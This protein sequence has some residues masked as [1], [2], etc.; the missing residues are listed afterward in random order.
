MPRTIA[1]ITQLAKT[2]PG[3]LTPAEVRFLRQEK[4]RQQ[5]RMFDDVPAPVEE[6]ERDA[7]VEAKRARRESAR[8]IAR[9]MT[10]IADPIRRRDLEADPAA[11]LKHYLPGIFYKPFSAN[12]QK[13][14][15]GTWSILK[16]GG[17]KIILDHRGGGKSST[18]RGVQ[19]LGALSGQVRFSPIIGKNF[20]EGLRNLNIQKRILETSEELLA[21]Y[22]EACVP[23]RR[24]E[25]VSQRASTM[26]YRGEVLQFEWKPDFVQ[27]PIIDGRGGGVL[28]ATGIDG[29][30]IRGISVFT[31]GDI[32][33]PDLVLLD[34]LQDEESARS[35]LQTEKIMDT[36]KQSVL[37]G[38]G[39]GEQFGVM[40][41]MTCIAP[42]DVADRLAN[43]DLYPTWRGERLKMVYA[44]P[45][46]M[47][48]W[49]A[50]E[51]IVL[52]AMNGEGEYRGIHCIEA[53]NDFVRD[54][55]EAMHEGA[56]LGSAYL[57]IDRSGETD[58]VS[59]LQYAMNERI[60][61]GREA[62]E[63]E[64]NNNPISLTSQPILT[65]TPYLVQSKLLGHPRGVVPDG[66][67]RLWCGCDVGKNYLHAVVGVTPARNRIVHVIDYFRVEI[68]A[69]DGDARDR[70]SAAHQLLDA[71]IYEALAHLRNRLESGYYQDTS[72]RPLRPELVCID[73]GFMRET[74]E[75]FCDE[76]ESLR[77]GMRRYLSMR[78]YAASKAQPRA[79][80][81]CLVAD[82]FYARRYDVMRSGKTVKIWRYFQNADQHK[83]L[84][85]EG[86]RQEPGNPGAVSLFGAHASEHNE[87]A[88]QIC[89]ETYLES[90]PGQFSF[91][92][93]KGAD[94]HYLDATALIMAALSRREIKARDAAIQT[95]PAQIAPG[96]DAPTDLLPATDTPA[97][98][99]E[100]PPRAD[101]KK[102]SAEN[103]LSPDTQKQKPRRR[104]SKVA[105]DEI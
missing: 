62:F 68:G 11:W 76:P 78:G 100:D 37:G 86:F 53:A 20:R 57:H 13:I 3:S 16:H 101:S 105:Y 66:F 34:D 9:H 61:I 40:A 58:C 27:L 10:P 33:R 6:R 56:R 7:D 54:H 46:R 104:R 92:H 41:A 36:I 88:H 28:S 43:R 64:Y 103:Q 83:M 94:N 5:P 85:H 69:V 31:Q 19:L 44:W 50:Y 32:V 12:Q 102:I 97:P 72:G 21:D 60:D 38:K 52:A 8:D 81:S 93:K 17:Q 14:I 2:D 39:H 4:A 23:V 98:H 35:S 45:K 65:V 24:L 90:K 84:V 51:D 80:E 63:A 99:S 15:D 79:S 82:H 49:Q 1:E 89:A 55:Y 67:S 91:V 75:R 95:T 48:L 29:G 25:G 22:P 42:D 87:Y 73:R 71:K 77:G 26:P 74:V 47:D 59:S 70:D 30:G 96:Q 18:F